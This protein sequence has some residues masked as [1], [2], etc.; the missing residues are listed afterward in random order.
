[1]DYFK[2]KELNDIIQDLR[3]VKFL[4]YGW[5]IKVE[6]YSQKDTFHLFSLPTELE[7][8]DPQKVK[9]YGNEI[10]DKL[11]EAIK[12]VIDQ[13]IDK[14]EAMLRKEINGKEMS[15]T[16]DNQKRELAPILR[17]NFPLERDMVVYMDINTGKYYYKTSWEEGIKECIYDFESGHIEEIQEEKE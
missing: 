13:L 6:N 11:N 9:N 14:Y 3:K 8:K 1:M 2:I 4:R 15:E 7:I 12:P 5:A 16:E 10:S 17:K